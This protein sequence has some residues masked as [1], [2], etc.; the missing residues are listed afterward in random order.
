MLTLLGKKVELWFHD[1]IEPYAKPLPGST[2]I[3][4]TIP[5]LNFDTIIILDSPHLQ[6]IRN[7]EAIE[8]L[9]SQFAP[10]VINIDHHPDNINFGTLNIVEPTISSVGELLF[11]IFIS[12]EWT[13]TAF[14]ATNLYAAISFDTGRFLFSN[15][16]SYTFSAASHLLNQGA[17]AYGISQNM[18]E[19]KSMKTF[20]VIK[21]A[22][23]R[24]VIDPQN[25]FAY[26][27]L[28]L[29][30]PEGEMKAID[31]IRQLGN[32]QVFL[33]L[34][35]QKPGE[36]KVNLRSK[37]SFNVSQFAA[38]FGGGG[39]ILAAGITISGSLESA[40]RMIITALDKAL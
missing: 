14:I 31:F 10:M 28:P 23:D 13:I 18:Y 33:V 9:I 15:V 11:H 35:E 24:L 3:L 26:T 21:I 39:H 12:Y 16:T 8:L 20:E 4:P 30:T 1:P 5:N 6:R 25:R 2:Q 22:L 40:T 32:I 37:S 17:D 36:I 38:Q 27:T 7:F 34:S 19:N 29:D